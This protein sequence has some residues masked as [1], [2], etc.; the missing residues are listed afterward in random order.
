VKAR[1]GAN[2]FSIGSGLIDEHELA[3]IK[4]GLVGCPLL[5]CLCDVGPILFGGVP[6][7]FEADPMPIEEPADRSLGRDQSK[8]LADPLFKLL[9]GQI[10][11]LR[12]KLQQPV[13]IRPQRRAA[14]AA[15]RPQADAAGFIMQFC[16]AQASMPTGHGGSFAKNART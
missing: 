16:P 12:H 1:P 15:A 10:G 6:H 13:R 2:H 4:A 8:A 11:F 9:Q 7:F 3:C 5:S 14:L